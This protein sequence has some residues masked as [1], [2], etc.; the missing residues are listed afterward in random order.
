MQLVCMRTQSL[1]TDIKVWNLLIQPMMRN[2]NL[3]YFN[4]GEA[5]NVS[6]S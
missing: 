6:V 1:R 3:D 2:K 4:T 5:L